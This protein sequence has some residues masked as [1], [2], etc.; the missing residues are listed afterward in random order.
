MS[1]KKEKSLSVK[2]LILGNEKDFKKDQP[3]KLEKEVILL[4]NKDS[5]P[6]L[7]IFKIISQLFRSIMLND[8]DISDFKN[9]PGA[10]PRTSKGPLTPIYRLNNDEVLLLMN[11]D[12][13]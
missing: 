4:T 8:R 11:P 5:R 6:Y 3:T 7:Y 12:I 2:L 1:L 10:I 13:W 9:S